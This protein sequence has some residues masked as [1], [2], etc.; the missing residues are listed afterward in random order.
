MQSTS[1]L[2]TDVNSKLLCF[3]MFLSNLGCVAK[4]VIVLLDSAFQPILN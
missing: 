4:Y 3:S 1:A 2:S